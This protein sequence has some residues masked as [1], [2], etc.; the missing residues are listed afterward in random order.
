MLPPKYDAFLERWAPK[1]WQP[2]VEFTKG[3]MAVRHEGF[4]EGKAEGR[5]EERERVLRVLRSYV[6]HCETSGSDIRR[7]M[8]ERIVEVIEKGE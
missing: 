3:L 7:T 5:Q 2:G 8:L 6:R 1:T 4:L